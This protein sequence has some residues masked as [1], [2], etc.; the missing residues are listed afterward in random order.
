MIL[1]AAGTR[2]GIEDCSDGVS[3]FGS[4]SVADLLHLLHVCI[5]DRDETNAGAIAFGVVTA[6]DLII[7][8]AIE[9]VR[10]DLSRHAELGIRPPADVRLKQDEVERITRDQR[11]IG[12]R[13]EIERTA[14]VRTIRFGDD[15]RRGYFH[16]RS[17]SGDMERDIDRCGGARSQYHACLPCSSKA[18]RFDIDI[19]CAERLEVEPIQ[20]FRRR[21]D[22][23]LES[24]EGV[25]YLHL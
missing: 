3:E 20:S 24:V 13:V 2:D 10:I 23:L 11:Q 22:R 17:S 9:A 21:L 5:R 16:G 18:L 15:S 14:D 1:V 6:I 19:L 7:N 12:G 25:L 8:A 4:E